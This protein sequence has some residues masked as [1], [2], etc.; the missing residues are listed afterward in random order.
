MF[1]I[2]HILTCE[3]AKNMWLFT[4]NFDKYQI[5]WNSLQQFIYFI[6]YNFRGAALPVL[7]G[8]CQPQS[9]VPVDAEN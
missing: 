9:A 1:Y 7:H 2:N 5:R 4:Q 3:R 6:E 8:E